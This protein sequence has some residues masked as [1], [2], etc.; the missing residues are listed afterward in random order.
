MKAP[1]ILAAAAVIA[2]TIGAG[3]APDASL[4]YPVV[5]AQAAVAQDFDHAKHLGFVSDGDA[6]GPARLDVGEAEGPGVL[7]AADDLASAMVDQVDLAEP[8]AVFCPVS[9]GTNGN[10]LLEQGTGL[11]EPAL[12]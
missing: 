9:P 5:E 11:G 3:P 6:F 8:R 2:A 7:T 12:P 1:V 4:T 10:A